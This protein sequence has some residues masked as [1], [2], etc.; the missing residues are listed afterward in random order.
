MNAVLARHLGAM[1][2]AW[3]LGLSA[4]AASAEALPGTLPLRRDVQPAVEGGSWMPSVLLL[5]LAV[6]AG[7][8]AWWRRGAGAQAQSAT[9]RGPA[10]IVRR[11]SQPLTPH[12]SVH[13]V[14]WN[15]EEFLLACTPQ[16]VTLLARR[17]LDA[18]EGGAP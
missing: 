7:G 10:A 3:L 4:A 11:S 18:A 5:G 17:P 8:Y 14:Q 15:G 12:A 1:L 16:Q 9:R 6:A 13:A 2:L